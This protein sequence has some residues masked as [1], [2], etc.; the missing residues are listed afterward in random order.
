ML[1]RR[2]RRRQEG[3]RSPPPL[4]HTRVS[5]LQLRRPNARHDFA[6]AS[7]R[8]RG[9]GPG[10]S[11]R[12]NRQPPRKKPIVVL[13]LGREDW[14]T[15]RTAEPVAAPQAGHRS[16]GQLACRRSVP[17]A[18]MPR[19]RRPPAKFEDSD[20]YEREQRARS[21]SAAAPQ[22]VDMRVV[23]PAEKKTKKKL[24]LTLKRPGGAG[25]GAA[26]SGPA[27]KRLTLRVPAAARPAAAAAAADEDDGAQ[28]ADPS[29]A[30]ARLPSRA[31]AAAGRS[32]A[33][34]EKETG[35]MGYHALRRLP[36]G[37]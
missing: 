19:P 3:G 13:L 10:Q 37:I 33:H 7:A 6:P 5:P 9:P 28:L 12:T 18:A 11:M 21:S 22:S 4:F 15:A 31:A 17:G 35:A 29:A 26:P 23:M 14:R 24:T 20:V 30:S 2:W 1:G 8:M 27:S 34:G 36:L 25:G 32:P 16:A